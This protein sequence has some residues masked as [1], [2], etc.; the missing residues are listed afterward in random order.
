MQSVDIQDLL[1]ERE[2]PGDATFVG[3]EQESLSGTQEKQLRQLVRQ[4]RANMKAGE[5]GDL[6]KLFEEGADNDPDVKVFKNALL[7]DIE[8]HPELYER[9]FSEA[10]AAEIL[11]QVEEQKKKEEEANKPGFLSKAWNFGKGAL[12]I[13]SAIAAPVATGLT[14]ASHFSGKG[15]R[16]R[17]KKLKKLKK[18]KNKRKK[19][20]KY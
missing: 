6:A 19:Y 9:E 5:T 14:I 13:A 12:G 16:R 3:N 2:N 1:I 15:Y 20:T 11:K 8:E 10:E 17:R 4:V 18:L 7:K